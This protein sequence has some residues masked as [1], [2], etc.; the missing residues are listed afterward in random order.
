M[1]AISDFVV[2]TLPNQLPVVESQYIDV[3]QGET[4]EGEFS[5]SDIDGNIFWYNLES[6]PEHG[7]IE[8]FG[9]EK[10]V[11]ISST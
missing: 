9:E 7:S 6:E 1:V 10:K 5:A 2:D 4:V 8:I 11:Q 3:D